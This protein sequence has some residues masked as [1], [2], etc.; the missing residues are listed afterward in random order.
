MK[1][2]IFFWSLIILSFIAITSCKKE[3]AEKIETNTS[4][5][6]TTSPI[7]A[8]S[9]PQVKFSIGSANFSYVEGKTIDGNI[10][11]TAYSTSAGWGGSYDTSSLVTGWFIGYD[12]T[13]FVWHNIM[14]VDFGT[15]KQIGG[16]EFDDLKNFITLKKY[17]FSPD[18]KNGVEV[19]YFDEYYYSTDSVLQSAG[20]EFEITEVVEAVDALGEQY[21]KFKAIFN[22]DLKNGTQTIEI[23]NATIVGSLVHY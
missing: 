11:N 4:T 10:I 1:T 20:N 21:L 15:L 5:S 3:E 13:A 12:D 2:K 18:A 14:S 7:T 16:I 23:R 19:T 22:C 9:T 17:E 8:N 6:T